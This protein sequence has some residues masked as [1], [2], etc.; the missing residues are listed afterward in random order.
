MLNLFGNLDTY[1]VIQTFTLHKTSSF[2][3]FYVNQL[4]VGVLLGEILHQVSHSQGRNV[5][6]L[7]FFPMPFPPLSRIRGMKLFL[8]VQLNPNYRTLALQGLQLRS[9]TFGSFNFHIF[10]TKRLII[11][12]NGSHFWVHPT[13]SYCCRFCFD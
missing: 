9:A 3:N 1:Y 5:W 7:M 6:G 11:K 8:G 4:V 13:Q 10:F 2:I 12:R